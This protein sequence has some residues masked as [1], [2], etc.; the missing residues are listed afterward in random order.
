MSPR[1]CA[2]PRGAPCGSATM[3]ARAF[4]RFRGSIRTFPPSVRTWATV[5][6]TSA[7]AR[8]V[9]HCGPAFAYPVTSTMPATS[10][11]PG[12]GKDI[13][14]VATFGVLEAPAKQLSIESFGGGDV[15]GHEVVPDEPARFDRV[16]RVGG[17]RR[18]GYGERGGENQRRAHRRRGDQFANHDGQHADTTP[19]EGVDVRALTREGRRFHRICDGDTRRTAQRRPCRFLRPSAASPWA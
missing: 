18:V 13:R 3:A 9:N 7:T 19:P 4:G 2:R 17:R 12:S 8:Y 16:G 11:A 10:I 14:T 1:T 15:L 6:S 5:L